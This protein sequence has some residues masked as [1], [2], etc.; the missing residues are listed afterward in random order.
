MWTKTVTLHFLL[1]SQQANIATPHEKNTEKVPV[2]TKED[3]EKP[4]ETKPAILAASGTL[5]SAP[6]TERPAPPSKP[7]TKLK[8]RTAR[9]PSAGEYRSSYKVTAYNLTA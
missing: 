1:I 9:I 4:K 8:T 6:F 3:S 5:Q 7:K 2:T